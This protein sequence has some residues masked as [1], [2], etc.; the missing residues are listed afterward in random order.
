MN[1]WCF[2][3]VSIWRRPAARVAGKQETDLETGTA[4]PSDVR[5]VF[6]LPANQH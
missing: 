1:E 6:G 4:L 2:D 3:V 5:K